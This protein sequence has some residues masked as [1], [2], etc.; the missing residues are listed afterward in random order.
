M[1]LPPPR[2]F[3]ASATLV[4]P[5]MSMPQPHPYIVPPS[6]SYPSSPYY[7]AHNE[8]PLYPSS[9]SYNHANS[10]YVNTYL[11][12]HQKRYQQEGKTAAYSD[13]G[14][15]R[16]SSSSAASTAI[17]SMERS[18]SLQHHLKTSTSLKHSS[19]TSS[20]TTTTTT[21][22]IVSPPATN[23]TNTPTAISTPPAYAF[24]SVLGKAFVRR[25][26]GLENVRELFCANEYPESFTGQEAIVTRYHT[27]STSACY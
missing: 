2:P 9:T 10:D 25:V 19:S 12:S 7:A 4:E 16:D 21:T 8:P 6:M 3:T 1:P 23:G 18:S 22:T 27:Y 14:S 17:S 20:A 15:N 24:L 11:A 13:D 5:N 26:R